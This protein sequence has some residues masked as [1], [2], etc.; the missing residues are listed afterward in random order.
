[1][2]NRASR[3]NGAETPTSRTASACLLARRP[4]QRSTGARKLRPKSGNAKAK[5]RP[6]IAMA[7]LRTSNGMLLIVKC[8]FM[9]PVPSIWPNIREQSNGQMPKTDAIQTVMRVYTL[10]IRARWL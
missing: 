1:M 9:N 4:A 7:A 3:I 5:S 8:R 10:K 2:G 6:M